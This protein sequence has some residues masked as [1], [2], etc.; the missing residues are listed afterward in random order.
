MSSAMMAVVVST[1]A[2]MRVAASLPTPEEILRAAQMYWP[3]VSE[4]TPIIATECETVEIP[5][6]T[7]EF[8]WLIERI[9]LEKLLVFAGDRTQK[10]MMGYGPRSNVLAVRI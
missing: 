8:E 7:Q 5:T 9:E 1:D 6:V 3:E 10:V 2:N 4:Q